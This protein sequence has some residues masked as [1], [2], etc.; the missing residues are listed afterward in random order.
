MEY[1]IEYKTDSSCGPYKLPEVVR[2][3]LVSAGVNILS[4][5]RNEPAVLADISEDKLAK[6]SA[7]DCV[8]AVNISFERDMLEEILRLST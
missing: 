7:L 3:Q 1:I 4:S 8:R 2:Q 6:V 5:K